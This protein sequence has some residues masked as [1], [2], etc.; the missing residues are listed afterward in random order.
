LWLVTWGIDLAGR[1][2]L[3]GFVS[4]AMGAGFLVASV[5][6]VRNALR[7]RRSTDA[8]DAGRVGEST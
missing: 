2:D 6:D 7:E 8:S 3:L 5:L 1:G 4:A